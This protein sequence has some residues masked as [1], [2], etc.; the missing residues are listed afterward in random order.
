MPFPEGVV[1][2]E[3]D[4]ILLAGDLTPEQVGASITAGVKS[5]I[6][7]GLSRLLRAAGACSVWIV[8]VAG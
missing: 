1:V 8:S 4:G 5:W 3:E 7:P 6:Y 2:Y